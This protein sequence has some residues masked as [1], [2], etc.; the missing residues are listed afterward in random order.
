MLFK[1][2]TKPIWY[3]YTYTFCE[4]TDLIAKCFV[5]STT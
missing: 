3:T 5:R 1:Y 4:M 2:L